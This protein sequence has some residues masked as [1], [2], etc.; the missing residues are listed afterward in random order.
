MITSWNEMKIKDLL[1]IRE[2]GNLQVASEDEKNMMIAAHLAGEEYKDVLLKPLDD[3]RGMITNADFLI[4]TKPVPE[5]ARKK[6]KINNRTYILFQNPGDM[7]VAQY[8]DFQQ[9][10]RE[11]FEKRPVE[12]LCIFLIP[13]GHQY[14]DGYDKEQ[15]EEDMLELGVE[16]AL[17]ICDFFTIRCRKSIKR[18]GTYLKVMMGI[19]GLKAPKEEKERIKATQIQTNLL[20]EGL[21]DL[22]G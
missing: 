14:N 7:S 5:K 4:D 20:L 10:F 6:Y 2:I 9:I 22:F 18:M 12:M 1:A 15:Q 8:I 16:E 17:G 3:V 13:D 11:G 21:A 19:Q